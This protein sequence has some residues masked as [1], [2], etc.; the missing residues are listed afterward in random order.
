MSITLDKLQKQIHAN[1]KFQ[2]TR[3]WRGDEIV[4]RALS[5]KMGSVFSYCFGGATSGLYADWLARR[6]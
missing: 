6:Q 2:F 3:N 4:T 5:L 1:Q